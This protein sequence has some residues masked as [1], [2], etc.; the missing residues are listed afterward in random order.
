MQT[1]ICQYRNR[2][3]ERDTTEGEGGRG[4]VAGSWRGTGRRLFCKTDWECLLHRHLPV[5][6]DPVTTGHSVRAEGPVR[7]G[8]PVPVE[9]PGPVSLGPPVPPRNLPR[10]GEYHRYSMGRCT[11]YSPFVSFVQICRKIS[12]LC[13]VNQARTRAR[14]TQPSPH[15]FL[16]IC[17][18]HP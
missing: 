4:G 5:H 2:E 8:P 7:A 1:K 3:G 14:V 6:G 18:V 16:H 9:P 17:T 11:R 13:C 12:G 15:I 10:V